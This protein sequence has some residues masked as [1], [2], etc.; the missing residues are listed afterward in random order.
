MYVQPKAH[1]FMCSVFPAVKF[2]A[3]SLQLADRGERR[4]ANGEIRADFADLHLACACSEGNR[5]PE[6]RKR[7]RQKHK[8]IR[9]GIWVVSILVCVCCVMCAQVL[10]V[11]FAPPDWP[12]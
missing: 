1:M 2:L 10:R 4:T 5:E 7:P 9:C 11:N 8:N 6:M 3:P 12:H